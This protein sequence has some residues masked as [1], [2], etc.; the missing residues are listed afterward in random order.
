MKRSV[1]LILTI[2]ALLSFSACGKVTQEV[3]PNTS[4]KKRG[5][6]VTYS[7]AIPVKN[8]IISTENQ[9]IVVAIKGL[10]PLE[11]FTQLSWGKGNTKA[12]IKTVSGNPTTTWTS[13]ASN[14]QDNHIAKTTLN[15]S[16]LSL[17]TTS[18]DAFE[19]I[20]RSSKLHYGYPMYLIEGYTDG[21]KLYLATISEK[22]ASDNS[23][24]FYGKIS[25]Y[26]TF[27]TSLFLKHLDD[28][29]LSL[30]TTITIS[31]LKSLFTESFFNIANYTYPPNLVKSF[32]PK[33]PRLLINRPLENQAISII[34]LL[35]QNQKPKAI[36][37]VQTL[38]KPRLS[39]QAKTLLTKAIDTYVK[40]ESTTSALDLTDSTSSANTTALDAAN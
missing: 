4:P 3:A 27:I 20:G 31:S 6:S 22:K 5:F 21:N 35:H 15:E 38:Q 14:R 13:T 24:I 11:G 9:A 30:E 16:H 7:L 18:G 36:K 12:T 28:Q 37:V 26:E 10:T 39:K 19:W 33:S 40:P 8:N 17:R 1:Y 29:D 2:G 32:D 25:P 34:N 23:V